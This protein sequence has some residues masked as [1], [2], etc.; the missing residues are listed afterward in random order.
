MSSPS[1]RRLINWV[2]RLTG[3]DQD[4]ERFLQRSGGGKTRGLTSLPIF[5]YNE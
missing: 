3:R 4:E 1:C 5:G 2:A